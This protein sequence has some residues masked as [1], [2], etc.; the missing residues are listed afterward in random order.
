MKTGEQWKVRLS[1]IIKIVSE[2]GET[3]TS[4]A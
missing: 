1:E 4:D 3:D 2:S